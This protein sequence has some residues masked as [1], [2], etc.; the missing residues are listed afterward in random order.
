VLGR[1]FSF[2]IQ[3]LARLACPEHLDEVRRGMPPFS[4]QKF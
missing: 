4:T 2:L 3:P 1:D